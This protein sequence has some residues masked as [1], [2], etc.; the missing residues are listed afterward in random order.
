VDQTSRSLVTEPLYLCSVLDC[1]LS[2]PESR[3]TFVAR[4]SS[5]LVVDFFK[6]LAPPSRSAASGE[7]W[8]SGK[9]NKFNIFNRSRSLYDCRA[10]LSINRVC[11]G[12]EIK[13]GI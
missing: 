12:R 6:S 1:V 8:V 13:I 2:R 9:G 11:A 10:R 5:H 7:S 4:F 3:N